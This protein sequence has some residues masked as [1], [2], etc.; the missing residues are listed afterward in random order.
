[1]NSI[2]VDLVDQNSGLPYIMPSD[3]YNVCVNATIVKN[4]TV[5]Y[6]STNLDEY[7]KLMKDNY[8]IKEISNNTI[9]PTRLNL[10]ISS[11]NNDAYTEY[12]L[13]NG[14]VCNMG[15]ESGSRHCLSEK[16]GLDF[17]NFRDS[18]GET[19][20][21]KVSYKGC[22]GNLETNLG[23]YMT[24]PI[25]KNINTCQAQ[26]VISKNKVASLTFCQCSDSLCNWNI[27]QVRACSSMLIGFGFD[28]YRFGIGSDYC[29]I[30]E[31]CM[32]LIAYDRGQWSSIEGC[33]S[34]IDQVL[35]KRQAVSFPDNKCADINTEINYINKAYPSTTLC[36]CAG[37]NS[38]KCP[39]PAFPTDCYS[40]SNGLDTIGI[41]DY[42]SELQFCLNKD[43]CYYI[44]PNDGPS[45]NFQFM[46]CAATF[47]KFVKPYI[48]GDFAPKTVK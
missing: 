18:Y 44:G 12:C 15:I 29:K 9:C 5:G 6:L 42:Y 35:A 46:G 24:K 41:S 25:T 22:L 36:S 3:T 45:Q 7:R 13:C 11:L 37:D 30:N 48:N 28:T 33:T 32:K 21:S 17:V 26:S 14:H 4:G 27:S 10:N 23:K 47:N 16:K 19:A 1:M 20:Y 43:P 8:D 39:L 40:N 31:E 38:Q 2:N 34:L